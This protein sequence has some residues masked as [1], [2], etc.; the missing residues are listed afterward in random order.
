MERI[1]KISSQGKYS[2][3][4]IKNLASKGRI[5]INDNIVK[6]VNEKIDIETSTIYID[7]EKLDF[8]RN[9][10]LILNKPKGYISASEDRSQKTVLDLIPEKYFRKGLFPAGRLDKDTT[11]MMII[12]DDG[13][14]LQRNILKR[15]IE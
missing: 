1:D 6:K 15:L 9:I 8:K 11:G 5:K 7:N 2:R 13:Y 10:Y 14:C 12:T 3:S 4:E